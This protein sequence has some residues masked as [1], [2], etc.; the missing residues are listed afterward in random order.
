MS[1]E[2]YSIAFFL[3]VGIAL[4]ILGMRAI[5]HNVVYR[6]KMTSSR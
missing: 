6:K 5:R 1:E 2:E 4:I 3:S